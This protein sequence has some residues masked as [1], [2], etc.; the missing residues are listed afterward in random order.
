MA[1]DGGGQRRLGGRTRRPDRREDPSA[2]R[3]EL[4][5]GRAGRSE[6]ELADPIA[7]EAGVRVA[8]D[9]P[10]DGRE[11]APVELLDVVA[12]PVFFEERQLAHRSDRGDAAVLAQDEAVGDH[13]DVP[14]PRPTRRRAAHGWRRDLGEVVNQKPFGRRTR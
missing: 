5:V 11:P 1:G 8:I 7:R 12:R 9:E 2:R 14:Q 10:W 6:R 3:V 13:V 4:L